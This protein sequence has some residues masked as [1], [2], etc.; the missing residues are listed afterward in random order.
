MP[1]LGME[2]IRRAALVKATIEE[3]GAAGS[4][5]VTVSVIA[6]R[7]GVSAALAHHYFGS[8]DRIFREAMRQIL[9][10]FAAEAVRGLHGATT[11]RG[12]LDAILAASFAPACFAPDVITAWMNLYSRAQIDPEARRLLE[13][14]QAR[15]RS[16]LCHALRPISATPDAL[17]T[18]RDSVDLILG[19]AR[20]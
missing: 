12:R 17:D 14:Y 1:K 10:D 11:S 18:L 7:A 2:P 6:R 13:G 20:G 8:K 5:D 4:L 3:I 15:L 19:E 9:R 16:N